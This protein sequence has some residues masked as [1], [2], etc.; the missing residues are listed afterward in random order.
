MNQ[1]HVNFLN[2]PNEMLFYILKKLENVDVLY[3]F[4]G[5]NNE[6]LDSIVENETFSNTLHFVSTIHNTTVIDSIVDRFCNYILPRIRY[7]VKCL[8]VE[9]ASMER[10]LL[11]THYPNLIEL[12]LC[13]FQRDCLLHYFTGKQIFYISSAERL[14]YYDIE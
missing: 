2:L 8:V 3:S 7:N 13:H 5:I 6:R 14:H 12:K 1:S 11:A 10:I 9:P 4:F